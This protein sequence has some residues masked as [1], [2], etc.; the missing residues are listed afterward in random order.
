MNDEQSSVRQG[1][2]NRGRRGSQMLSLQ[3]TASLVLA[4]NVLDLFC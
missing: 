4:L 2:G 3:G 1:E